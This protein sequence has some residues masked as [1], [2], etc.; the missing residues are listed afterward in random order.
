M[1]RLTYILTI[2]FFISYFSIASPTNSISYRYSEI[3]YS[4]LPLIG[5]RINGGAKYTNNKFIEVEIKS[6]KTAKSLI[7]SMKIG[8]DFNLSDS[9]WIPYSE[10]VIKMQIEGED[11]EKYIYAQLKDKAGNESPVEKNKIILDTNPPING[12]I[13]LNKGEK[14]FN[15][16]LGRVM[17]SIK[18]ED[19]VEIMI[20]NSSNFQNGRWE[21]LKESMKWIVDI[22]SGNGEKTVFAKFRDLAGNESEFTSSS[23]IMDISPP[24]GGTIVINDGEKY[25]RIQ[26]F[27]LT[28]TSK[29]ATR[30]RIV[31]NGVG[32]YYDF[33]PDENG[34]MNMFWK[35]DS[36]QGKKIVKA[37]FVDEAKNITKIPAEASIIYKTTAP[38]KPHITIDQGHK[39]TNNP[40]GTVTLKVLSK[41][42]PLNLKMLVSNKP[43]FDGAK[44]Q[45]FKSTLL[46]WQLDSE[47][48]GLKSIYIK[49]IDPANNMSEVSR[50]DIFLDRTPPKINS[51][52]INNKSE[53]SISLKVI[54]YSDIDDAFE[55][56]YSNSP[57]NLRNMKWEIYHEQR[58]DWGILAVDGEKIVYAR[59]KD[60][61]GNISEVVSTKIKLDMTPPKGAL[62]LN[63]GK[64]VTN[65][66]DGKVNLQINHDE[67]VMG[68]QIT[69]K[70]DFKDISIL[71]I[72]KT[73]ENWQLD[74]NDDGD[75]TVYLRLKDR[76]GNY[77]KV[78]TSSIVLDRVAPVNN[79]LIINN[80]DPFVRNKNKRV[81]L[82]FRSEGATH[83]MVSNKPN[84]EGG[85]WIPFKSAI[86]WTLEGA[87]GT[88][89]VYAKFKDAAGNETEVISKMIKSDYTPPKIVKF[90]IDNGA[91]YS[92]DP[93]SVVSLTFNVENTV[94]MAISNTQLKDT[95][96]LN[97]LWEPYQSTKEWKLEGE[98]GLKIIYCR[99]KDE[100]GNITHEYYSKIV[101][102]R[103]PPADG[104]VMINNGAEWLTD[105]S[106]KGEIQLYAKDAHE[107]MISNTPNYSKGKW[108]SMTTA[109]KDWI[110]DTRKSPAIVYAQFRDKA[111]NVSAPVSA[112]I[113]IDNDPPKNTSISI[114]GGAKFVADK[115]R[116]IKIEMNA[117]GATGMRISQFKNFRDAKWEPIVTSKEIILSPPDGEKTFYIQ[118]SDDAGNQSEI[119][120]SKIILDTTP[121]II[122]KFLIND[123]AEWS[124]DAGKKVNLSID[125]EGASEM[126]IGTR[127]GLDN[128]SW[129]PFKSSVSNYELSGDDGEKVLYLKLKDESGNISKIATAKIKLKRSF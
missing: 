90:D 17:V 102:D 87:E 128:S 116:K 122:K 114:N 4:F 121:P 88:H 34:R 41:E 26:K 1:Y 97:N 22:G 7:E 60:E 55:A 21:K 25:S 120:S 117:E 99:F 69:N 33:K 68:M 23:I 10:S 86:A 72:E 96:Q 44:Q 52:N 39:Y 32:K 31:S 124:N 103:I 64:K 80:N 49:L 61:A 93:Q 47:V 84:M 113:Q 3:N 74:A 65:N 112:S 104:K 105:I 28:L 11:G 92:V 27:K 109:K 59:F 36:L 2:S 62:I 57:N 54:L 119:I 18:A 5:I 63:G 123:G 30:V 58:P 43:N 111:G 82:S 98:D 85:E 56:Q 8:F 20:S 42:N 45:P 125:A 78:Y 100:A 13:I 94:S 81:S 89:N 118:F 79:E 106:G 9:E 48:D 40:R 46:N 51:F 73:I 76:A 53:W 70:P 95:S 91:E 71:P 108:E 12:K 83:I 38:V 24:S 75:K 107:F 115:E 50:A 66:P 101:L 37:Y 67:D 35:A 77:S 16:K 129:E 110:F 127:P 19:A 29:D 126:V 15:D 6:L 14:Y